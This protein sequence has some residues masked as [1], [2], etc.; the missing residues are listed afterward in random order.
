ML[1]AEGFI[2]DQV[3][4]SLTKLRVHQ[5]QGRSVGGDHGARD[6]INLIV[7]VPQCPYCRSVLKTV[8]ETVL[9]I[10]GVLKMNRCLADHT[11]VLHSPPSVD[12]LL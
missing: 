2:C 3:F 4:D 8:K 7:Q 5:T 1:T 10:K 11:V 12:S 6:V 9:H